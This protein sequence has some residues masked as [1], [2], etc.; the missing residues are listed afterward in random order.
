MKR[1][2]TSINKVHFL[3]FFALQINRMSV[4]FD[5]YFITFL[6]VHSM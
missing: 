6:T 3:T 5:F 2:I 4:L 1:Y